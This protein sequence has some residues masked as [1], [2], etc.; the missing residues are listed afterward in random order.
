[1]LSGLRI[2]LWVLAHAIGVGFL[3][4]ALLPAAMEALGNKEFLTP[5]QARQAHDAA[6][7]A[8]ILFALVFAVAADGFAARGRVYLAS[9]LSATLLWTAFFPLNWGPVAFVALVPF[10]T[11]VRAEGVG[12]WRRYT[13]AWV[14]G[15]T[16]GALAINWVRVAHPMMALFAWPL[17][18]LYLSLYWPAALF[19][20]RRLD[21]LGQPPLALTLPV[22]WV[23]LEFFK[24]HF[25][26]GFPFLRHVHLHQLSGIAWYFLGHTQHANPPLLQTADLG[27]V[28]LISGAVAAVNGAVHD[29]AVRV[30]PFRWLVGLPRGW[31]L[32]VFRKEMMSTAGALT[33]LVLLL[34]YGGFRLIHKPFETGPRVALLQDDLDQE[35]VQTD[36]MLLFSRYDRLCRT[37]ANASPPPD[38]IVWPEACFPIAD[39]TCP[40]GMEETL[41]REWLWPWAIQEGRLDTT[42]VKSDALDRPEVRAYR[43]IMAAGRQKHAATHW[44]THVLL[45]TNGVDWDGTRD[46]KYNSARLL[47]PDGT[48]GPRYDKCHLVPFGEYVPFR[49][50]LPFLANFTPNPKD[51]LCRPGDELPRF[52]LVA[53]KRNADGSV[54][55]VRYRF[56]VIICYEDSE[57][58]LAR[59]YNPWSGEA[60]PADFLVNMSLDSWFDGTEEHEQHLAVSRFRAVEARRSVVRAVNMG[61]SAIIDPDG[62]VLKTVDFEWADSKKKAGIVADEVPI[63]TRGSVYAAVGDWVPVL[64][65]AGVLAGVATVIITRRK[66]APAPAKA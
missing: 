64:C 27:G 37:A 9:V 49:E 52:E 31:V 56:G 45:G 40:P 63:D 53:A 16:F 6:Q 5:I 41:P 54:K 23:A 59:R 4:L 2:A 42:K 32:P 17:L 57:P 60:R 22:V 10:A 20:L 1:M 38:L 28:Y 46:V 26:T 3:T 12:R 65:W 34:G 19:L 25:P 11:L 44:R 30:R 35:G 58:L 36:S 33:L 50:T 48:P 66:R 14:G 7:P 61:I 47:K 29:W 39:V 21:R 55:P 43:E 51:P 13:A 15:L 8:L 62:R 24:A 18:A